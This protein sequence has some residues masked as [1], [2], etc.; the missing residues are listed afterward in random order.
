VPNAFGTLS[1][2]R[3]FKNTTNDPITRLRFR[4]VDITT[5][6][7]PLAS[8][9]Q[10]DMR[11][12]SSTGTVTNSQGEEVITVTGLTLEEPPA[13]ANGGGL[14]STLTVALPGNMLAPGSSIDVQF[15]LGV[16]QQGNFRFLVNV[17]ALPGLPTTPLAP[18]SSNLRNRDLKA[19]GGGK[20]PPQER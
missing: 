20:P 5:L 6:N 17:E 14:N 8:A 18:D 3:R 1:I 4:V 9:P 12:L 13:Q 10:A 7:T 16:Q 15:L 2:Q 19:T 11:V